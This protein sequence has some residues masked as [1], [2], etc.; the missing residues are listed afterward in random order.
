MDGDSGGAGTGATMASSAVAEVCRV[1]VVVLSGRAAA[2][3]V[4]TARA[5][6]RRVL[7]TFILNWG[8][9]LYRQVCWRVVWMSVEEKVELKESGARGGLYRD[10]GFIQQAVRSSVFILFSEQY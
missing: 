8:A 10:V 7:M 9:G 5:V 4:V 3:E 6:M 1:F 2:I